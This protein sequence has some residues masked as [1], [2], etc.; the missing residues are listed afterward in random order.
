MELTD[1]VKTQKGDSCVG[2]IGLKE[3]IQVVLLFSNIGVLVYVTIGVKSDVVTL[4]SKVNIVN[5]YYD[6][7]LERISKIDEGNGM[8]TSF[9][10]NYNLLKSGFDGFDRIGVLNKISSASISKIS[11]LSDQASIVTSYLDLFNKIIQLNETI[12]NFVSRYPTKTSSPLTRLFI[13]HSVLTGT[14]CPLTYYSNFSLIGSKD[15]IFGE[16]YSQN[17]GI[18]CE[19]IRKSDF[20]YV[21]KNN[22]FGLCYNLSSITGLD[23]CGIYYTK[24]LDGSNYCQLKTINS[25]CDL[26]QIISSTPRILNSVCQ[27]N[28]NSCG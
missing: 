21:W 9:N 7:T 18:F 14:S 25:N 13:T 11:E 15:G 10:Q 26:N 2:K 5:E 6:R 19:Y 12:I 16:Y 17:T 1:K 20:L 27:F 28:I 23:S 8:L 24:Q 3:L 4:Q 22:V